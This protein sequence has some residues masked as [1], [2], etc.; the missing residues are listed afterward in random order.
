LLELKASLDG[1]EG[2]DHSCDEP[3]IVELMIEYF[4]HFDYPRTTSTASSS[5]V[6]KNPLIKHAKVFA[7]A[8]K[9]QVDGLRAL[10]VKKFK[11]AASSDWNND[12]FAQV[13]QVVYAS[14]PDDV[15]ELRTI[16]AD[17]IHDHFSVLKDKEDLEMVISG[18]GDLSYSLLR[19]TS[20]GF[21]CT[22]KHGRDGTRKSCKCDYTACGFDFDICL[23]CHASRGSACCP[24]CGRLTKLP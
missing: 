4:Y 8:I 10:A 13:V 16:T 21:R 3:E 18:L 1:A 11:E 23:Q 12:D 15:Q 5:I 24:I 14:T 2:A 22:K 9:Y 17:T 6:A 20:S 7:M 19:R